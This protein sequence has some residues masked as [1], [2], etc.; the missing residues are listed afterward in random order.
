MYIV[1]VEKLKIIYDKICCI[2]DGINYVETMRNN[3]G[4]NV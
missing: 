4:K 1:L 2:D 3:S